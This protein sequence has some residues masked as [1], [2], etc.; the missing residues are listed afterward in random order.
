MGYGWFYHVLASSSGVSIRVTADFILRLTTSWAD[1]ILWLIR[2]SVT[3]LHF[4]LTY[5]LIYWV[6]SR[7]YSAK[8]II[9]IINLLATNFGYY[10]FRL[11]LLLQEPWRNLMKLEEAWRSLKAL[12][13][14]DSSHS[15]WFEACNQLT[16]SRISTQI[17]SDT[18]S[19]DF[20]NNT[21]CNEM[22]WLVSI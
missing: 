10:W 17:P 7:T 19:Q 5:T 13:S 18:L 9:F 4:R 20:C 1:S 2:V 11:L 6:N 3:R 15:I 21:E 14:T 12:A 16:I 22:W 8:Y